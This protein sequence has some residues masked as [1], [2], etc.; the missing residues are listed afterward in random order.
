MQVKVKTLKGWANKSGYLFSEN[1]E[2]QYFLSNFQKFKDELLNEGYKQ[3]NTAFYTLRGKN[4]TE[5]V[6]IK[7]WYWMGGW[8]DN[9]KQTFA[10]FYK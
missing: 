4:A 8:S 6:I 7:G 9:K 3:L 10:V 5:K 2:N 1:T